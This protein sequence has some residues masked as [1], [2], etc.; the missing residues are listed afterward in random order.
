MDIE[1]RIKHATRVDIPEPTAHDYAELADFYQGAA[2]AVLRDLVEAKTQ[3]SGS[4]A[5][6]DQ[7][8]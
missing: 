3:V 5:S 6:G 7:S 1:A 4:E 8:S 2:D